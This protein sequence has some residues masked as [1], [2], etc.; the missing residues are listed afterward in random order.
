MILKILPFFPSI[1]NISS[2]EMNRTST[3]L[4][5]EIKKFYQE[6]PAPS[7]PFAIKAVPMMVEMQDAHSSTLKPL[8]NSH[9]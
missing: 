5:E 4:M 3:E 8:V 9:F 6:F 2:S 7:M 1:N